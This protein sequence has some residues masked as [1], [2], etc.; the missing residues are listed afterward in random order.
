VAALLLVIP[1]LIVNLGLGARGFD[2]LGLAPLSSLGVLAIAT[3]MVPAVVGHWSLAAVATSL[4]FLLLVAVSGRLVISWWSA[5]KEPGRPELSIRDR[6]RA[7]LGYRPSPRWWLSQRWRPRRR[8]TWWLAAAGL[9]AGLVAVNFVL[10]VHDP[11]APSQTI[12][13]G[14][15]YNAVLAVLHSGFP[16]GGHVG[17]A[18][19]VRC[20][21]VVPAPVA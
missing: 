8:T 6:W 10:G 11:D 14:F 7:V 19:G 12:D 2:A 3:L 9:A 5:R 13:A 15:H 21:G 1:G 18:S 17:A 16:D 20:D 4:A